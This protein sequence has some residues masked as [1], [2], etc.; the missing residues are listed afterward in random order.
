MSEDDAVIH[1]WE[2][3]IDQALHNKASDI[4]IEP[5][6]GISHIRLRVDGRLSH[7]M[8]SPSQWHERIAS[9][10]KILSR[11]DIS[12]KRLPQDGQMVVSGTNQSQKIDCR[13]S[14]LPTLHGEK[15]VVRLLNK[16]EGELDIECLGLHHTQ[17]AQLKTALN[18]PQGLILVTGPT[19]SG[20][21]QTLYS[22]LKYLLDGS[23]NITSIEDPI[24]IQL[25]GIQQVQVNEKSGLRFDVALRAIMR[26]DPDVIMVGEIRDAETAKIAFQA[27]ETG[28]LVLSTLHAN[29]APSAL[30]RLKQLH[31][32]SNHLANNLLCVTAQRLIR[33]ICHYCGGESQTQKE[34]SASPTNC[35]HC[36][37][38]GFKGRTGVHQ[39]MP[40]SKPL[41]RLI[42]TQACLSSIKEQ[43]RLEGIANLKES[44]QFLLERGI[45]TIREIERQ[46]A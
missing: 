5:E 12:E 45:T 32:D 40:L 14:T 31:V 15:I 43:C 30:S 13:I 18:S 6:Q 7:L 20:K 9:R 28:H 33:L 1:F 19:G 3:I 11:L 29:D 26:Q 34:S 24:E 46:I 10:I 22:C 21:T 23:R 37:N 35:L 27:A 17:L 44:A 8:S 4:H 16:I 2:K 36:H 25:K 42:E 38:S 41:R 39:L